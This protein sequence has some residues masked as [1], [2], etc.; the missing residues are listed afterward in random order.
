MSTFLQYLKKNNHIT[1]VRK[2]TVKT[3][4]LMLVQKVFHTIVFTYKR[5]YHAMNF[6]SCV[7]RKALNFLTIH[8]TEVRFAS[9]LSG[10]FI[11]AIH[12]SKST[13]KETGKTHLCGLVLIAHVCLF[14]FRVNQGI[15]NTGKFKKGV[16]NLDK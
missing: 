12:S 4:T 1:I 5:S 11:T 16:L 14:L 8:C 10:G 7:A 13:R 6:R 15:Y 2:Y 9:F 3:E